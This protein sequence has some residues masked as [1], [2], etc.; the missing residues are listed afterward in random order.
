MRLHNLSS[1]CLG[2]EHGHVTTA[3]RR[4]DLV[5]HQLSAENFDID[6]ERGG[7]VLGGIARSGGLLLGMGGRVRPP[8]RAQNSST[9]RSN[10]S[11]ASHGRGGH[12]RTISVSKDACPLKLSRRET[13]PE[14][15]LDLQPAGSSRRRSEHLANGVLNV[16]AAA[17]WQHTAAI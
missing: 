17:V 5:C 14:T 6:A 9:Q 7:L 2:V 4:R 10:R 15:G 1:D 3:V 11:H 8:A 12:N 16:S 13:D